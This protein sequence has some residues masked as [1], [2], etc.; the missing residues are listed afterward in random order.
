M[1]ATRIPRRSAVALLAVSATGTLISLTASGAAADGP[2]K[3]KA[4]VV[5]VHGAFA[6][7]SSWNGVITHLHRAGFPVVS[8]ANPLRGLATDATYVNNVIDTIDGPIVLVGHSYGG[9]VI[10]NAVRGNTNVKALVYVAG[11]A[12]DAGETALGLSEKFPG[13]TLGQTLEQIPLDGGGVDLRVRQ[14]LFAQQFA[15]DVPRRDARL[16]AVAQRPIAV[17]ALTEPSGTP[18]WRSVRSYH[19]IPE[20]DKNIP[21][22]SLAFMAARA[23][24]FTVTVKDASHAVLVSR[25]DLT[26]RL[27]ERAAGE[28]V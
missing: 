2:A 9:A 24:G 26:A 25:P 15:A 4:T 20:A 6:D 3:P 18:A 28:A 10:T 13:S 8:V 5:L 27:I 23:N 19:L 11:F 16:M 22:A 14:E 17:A 21:P 12:P 1:S 7:S